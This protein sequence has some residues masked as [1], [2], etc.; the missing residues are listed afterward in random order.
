M[1][2]E[3]HCC[4]GCLSGCP[5][6]T[7]RRSFLTSAGSMALAAQMGIFEFASSLF[8]APTV[9]AQRPRVR[10]AF[11]RPNV[12]KYWMGWPGASYDIKGSQKMYKKIMTEAA[13]KLGDDLEV[14]DEPIYND[15][16]TKAFVENVKKA[17]LDG[18]VVTS[19]EIRNPNW[20]NIKEIALNRG[21]VP[22][23]VFSPMGTSFTSHFQHTRDIPGVFTAATQEIN[24]L[25]T[26]I[27]MLK[28]VWQ[29]KNTRL[30][31]ITGGK[32][33][34]R[35]IGGLGTTLHY[36]PTNRFP[37]ELSK[38]G[39]TDEVRA[40]SDYFTKEAKNIVEPNK[41]DILNAAKNY[42]VARRIMDAEKCDGI[43]L[44]CLGLVRDHKIPCPPC[45]AWLKLNDEG[46]VGACE[47]DW[48][49]AISLRLTS[50]LCDRPGFMQDPA[51]NTVNNTLMGA[52]CSCPTKFDGFNSP[53]HEPFIL[54][55]HSESAIGVSPQVLWRI[56]QKVTVME[57]AG[58]GKSYADEKQSII[59][60]TGRVLRNIETPP[61]GGCR[62]SVE[63]EMD[64]VVDNRDVK[65][66]HQL[67]IYGD[68]KDEFKAY[69]DLANIKFK[70]IA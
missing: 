14:I 36:I 51:P 19:M 15:K 31:I 27:K 25:A 50:L 57:F 64:D 67:F 4:S 33:F 40:L 54:R 58:S 1:R 7:D 69:C 5:V 59:L 12:E 9:S 68:W 48:N 45:M 41:Q 55:N 23:I 26:G 29:M 32:A 6:K 65:G 53:G 70:P 3:K 20:P 62:T 60:G 22:M 66:F 63:L 16:T 35:Q 18:L 38:V 39:N 10:A 44:N 24:W 49:A 46:S 2:K 52:H 43:S 8:G 17:K 34:D 42:V 28:T 30:C 37:E 47:A 56:G 11:V 13:D 61:A 21:D